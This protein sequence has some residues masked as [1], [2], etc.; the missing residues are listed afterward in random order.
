MPR[1]VDIGLYGSQGKLHDL[2]NFLVRLVLDMPKHDA[3]PILRPQLGYGSLDRGAELS[4]LELFQGGFVAGNDRNRRG[5][6][7]FGRHRVGSSL[8]TYGIYPPAAQMID[9]EIVR[10]LEE[11]AREL[12]LGA[13]AVEVV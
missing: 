3:G 2:C 10:D 5:L 13:V 6:G 12:E 1:A 7:A 4:R 9:R 8:D 11:P